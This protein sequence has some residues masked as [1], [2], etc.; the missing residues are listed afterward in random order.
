MKVAPQ[1]KSG[2][3]NSSTVGLDNS[4]VL[5]EKERICLSTKAYRTEEAAA[6]ACLPTLSSRIQERRPSRSSSRLAPD[7]VIWTFSNK[8]QQEDAKPIMSRASNILLHPLDF[9]IL[10]MD[11]SWSRLFPNQ[12]QRFLGDFIRCLISKKIHCST[13]QFTLFLQVILTMYSHMY[14]N[15]LHSH[16]EKLREMLLYI[17]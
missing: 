12:R 3:T 16:H 14:S 8:L 9:V 13:N 10:T 7:T 2:I 11:T 6:L 4:I 5:A 17:Q 15:Q 1:S